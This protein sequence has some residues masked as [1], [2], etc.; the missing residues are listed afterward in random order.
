M[1]HFLAD[2]EGPPFKFSIECNLTKKQKDLIKQKFLKKEKVSG[3]E[4]TY[5][6]I[7]TDKKRKWL[8]IHYKKSKSGYFTNVDSTYPN[9]T[10]NPDGTS[11]MEDTGKQVVANNCD[12]GFAFVALFR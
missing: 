3:I 8:E 2:F 10:P 11:M 5:G 6:S 4:L 7:T 12:F 9:Y 1:G